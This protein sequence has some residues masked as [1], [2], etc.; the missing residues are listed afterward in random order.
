MTPSSIF[1]AMKSESPASHTTA[2]TKF[3]PLPRGSAV[4]FCIDSSTLKKRLLNTIPSWPYARPRISPHQKLLSVV[5]RVR[6][7][8]LLWRVKKKKKNASKKGRFMSFA[9][10]IQDFNQRLTRG[11]LYR[12]VN[13]E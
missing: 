5:M 11:T 8:L 9:A 3:V 6:F 4:C 10:T 2:I 13:S 1:L 7:T 12:I